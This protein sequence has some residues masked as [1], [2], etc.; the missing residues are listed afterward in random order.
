VLT[1]R[2]RPCRYIPCVKAG[3]KGGV[4]AQVGGSP[5]VRAEELLRLLAGAVTAARLYPA[6]SPLR[7]QAVGRF[8]DFARAHTGTAGPLQFAVDRSRFIVAE[9]AIGEASTQI[10]ALAE[11]LHALQVGRL[12][13]A[14]GVSETEV[15]ALL[16]ILGAEARTVRASGGIRRALLEAGVSNI[17]V[18]EV[19]L[20]AS[21]EDGLLGVDLT[22]AALDDLGGEVAAAASAWA[23]DARAGAQAVDQVAEAVGRLESAARD[24]A[25]QRC[26][27]SL[28]DEETRLAVM[29]AAML[30]DGG[31]Q[32]MDGMLDVIAKM[33]PA[34]L[35]RLLK[36]VAT[37]TGAET[38]DVF[39][40]LDLPEGLAREVAALL[41]PGAQSQRSRGV[42]EDPE[43]DAMAGIVAASDEDDE[44][45]IRELISA[46]PSSAAARALA[47]TVEVTRE[48]RSEDAVQ[49]L[50]E[51]LP[52]AADYGAFDE[53]GMAAELLTELSSE[54]GIAEA[55]SVA[56]RALTQPEILKGAVSR[57]ATDPS[58]IA[59]R[60]LLEA[61]GPAGAETL[62]E[63]YLEAPEHMRANL[64]PV[65]GSMIE[66]VTPV[67]GR[68]MRSGEVG[69]AIAVVGLLGALHMRRVIPTIALAL[70]HL[71]NQ[72][73]KA[74]IVTIAD[75]DGSERAPLLQRALG[76]WD[77]ETRRLA[78]REI[79][80]ARVS[81]A[82]P[83]LLKIVAEV[84]V[85]ERNYELKK[86][87]LQSLAALQSPEA[88]PTLRRLANRPFVLG[89]KNRELRYLAQR[90]LGSMGDHP[91]E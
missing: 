77:P 16:E 32:R 73:R 72:V 57:M 36:L 79:G 15:G 46:A 34:S 58:A 54:P 47:T 44:A 63:A 43:V 56:K 82:V 69:A 20:R 53:I 31:G 29:G 48:R 35:A 91:E 90:A 30:T 5:A 1:A 2:R 66:S 65:V 83:A 26:A 39:A 9:T 59:P 19:S 21:T 86:E 27:E 78:A 50:T 42:P 45:H 87:V 71:D 28:L 88:E 74:A 75:A 7:Q 62:I 52:M 67:A 84:S 33:S 51:A 8:A 80:R 55:V 14:P 81:D 49:A 12:I 60:S 3:V 11:A 17:A 38:S 4:V 6:T 68:I 64:T 22:S 25:M 41:S 70:D 85:F 37:Q 61:A 23:A 13:I 40:S 76:H 10:A 24:L 89:K 18:V